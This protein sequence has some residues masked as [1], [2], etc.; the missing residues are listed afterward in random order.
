MAAP[1][2][3][4]G[5]GSKGMGVSA[6]IGTDIKNMNDNAGLHSASEIDINKIKLFT[7]KLS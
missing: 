5:L 7:N 6:L 2:K 3:K 1:K 4:G